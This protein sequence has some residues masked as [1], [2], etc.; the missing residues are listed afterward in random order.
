MNDTAITHEERVRARAYALWE[1]AGQPE[2]SADMF[3]HQAEAELHTETGSGE[4]NDYDQTVADSF[5]ASDPPAHSGT[6]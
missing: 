1:A 2:G 3:W 6:T 4:E 5:P